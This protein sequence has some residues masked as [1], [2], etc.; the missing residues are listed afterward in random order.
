MS[1]ANS[2]AAPL[3]VAAEMFEKNVMGEFI[4]Q[5]SLKNGS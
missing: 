3:D 4:F 2:A 5:W 1:N